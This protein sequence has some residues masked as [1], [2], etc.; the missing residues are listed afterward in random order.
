MRGSREALLPIA[1]A[2]ALVV[3]AVGVAE[4][5]SWLGRPFPGFLVLRNRVVASAGL[6]HWPAVARGEI[7]QKEVVAMDGAAVESAVAIRDRVLALPPGTPVRYR[8]RGSSGEFERVIATRRFAGR[9]YGLLF[10]VDLLNGLALAGTA[11]G[12]LYLGRRHPAA[13]ASVPV[14]WLAGLWSLTALDLYGPYRLFRL[15]ALCEVLLFPAALHMALAFPRPNG[16]VRRHPGIV[17]L[18]YFLALGLGGLYQAGLGHPGTYVDAH[19]FA[20]S[21]LGVSLLTLIAMQVCRYL[22]P[23]TAEVRCTLRI[24]A[25]GALVAL[26]LPV[27]LTIAEPVTGGRMSQNALG[28]T[29]F[30]F[31]LSIGYAVCRRGLL[32]F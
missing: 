27:V 10:G 29:G 6:P 12:I 17:A 26:S 32:E 2:L 28:F 8:F 20:T 18:P 21:A 19:L 4:S 1:T 7:Y 11:L 13:G 31:P 25:M 30:L 16:F 15:H 5:V 9:D 24:V 14:L 23:E 22:H 3:L